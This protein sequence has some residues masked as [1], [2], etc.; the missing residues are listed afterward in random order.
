M[1]KVSSDFDFAEEVYWSVLDG[2]EG[3][4]LEDLDAL[5]A[6][7]LQ[8]QEAIF[9]S[10]KE[11]VSSS[12]STSS[13]TL[14]VTSSSMPKHNKPGKSKKR[15]GPSSLSYC[16]ICYDRKERHQM[17]RISGCSHSFCAGC[18]STYVKTRLEQNITIIMC[19]RENCKVPLELEACKPRFP[20]EV[21]EL[22]GDLL[23]DELLCATGGKLYCPFK[24]CSALLLND[25]QEVIA[26]TEC[27]YCH[28]L[29]CARCKVSWHSGISCEEYQK[30]SEDERGSEDLM[31][32]N[33]AKE[34]KWN[35]CPRCHIIVEKTEGVSTNFVMRVE[36]S[37]LITMVAVRETEKT[38]VE[39][40]YGKDNIRMR[41]SS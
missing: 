39:R 37:G 1:A 13:S 22:W 8:F 4:N 11:N 28:R 12:S 36:Q 9:L 26:E 32:R 16:E 17:F 25:N 14:K 27:P 10:V 21:I 20:K 3:G 7:K 24:D 29:L 38:S 18:I 23:R 6:E 19:P 31:V 41:N 15:V 40:R 30:L 5:L 2:N 33:L 35:R 34:K